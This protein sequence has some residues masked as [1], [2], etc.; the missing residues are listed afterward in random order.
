MV[1]RLLFRFLLIC[2]K[3]GAYRCRMSCK[4]INRGDF[5]EFNHIRCGHS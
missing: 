1:L 5:L 3:T 2:L 4:P